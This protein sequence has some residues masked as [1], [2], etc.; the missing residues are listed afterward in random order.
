MRKILVIEGLNPEPWT[1]PDISMERRG[2]RT[3]PRASKSPILA[4][5]QEALR[6]NIAEAYPDLPMMPDVHLQLSFHFWRKLDLYKTATGR[7]MQRKVAD[8]TNLQK[9]TEDALQGILFKN[10]NQVKRVAS[11]IVAE[12]VD[13]EP[14]IVVICDVKTLSWNAMVSGYEVAQQHLAEPRP[15]PPGNVLYIEEEL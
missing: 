14:H 6:E 11:E 1:A 7:N 13:V 3:Y 5:Y 2:S 8:A 4:A 9:A 10:D 12:G 15:T